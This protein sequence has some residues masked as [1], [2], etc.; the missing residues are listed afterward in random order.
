MTRTEIEVLLRQLKGAYSSDRF[1]A[2]RQNVESVRPEEWNIL[3]KEPSVG[4]QSEFGMPGEADLSI[5]Q[6]VLHVA[7]GL[8]MWGNRAF[9]DG[10]MQWH[11]VGRPT[12]EDMSTVLAW[13]AEGQE[14]FSAELAALPGDAALAVERTAPFATMMQVRAMVALVINHGLYH[15]GEVNRQRALIRDSSGWER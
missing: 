5:C 2:F 12:A 1:H 10:T 15:S 11:E 13:L 6:L 9:G 3:P 8:R 4:P 7:G 14:R